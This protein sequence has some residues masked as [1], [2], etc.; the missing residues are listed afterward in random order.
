M[1][2]VKVT[3]DGTV[4]VLMTASEARAVRDDL[5]QIKPENISQPGDD[6]HSLLKWATTP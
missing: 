1:E 4:T 6:L 3:N 2:I 5:D